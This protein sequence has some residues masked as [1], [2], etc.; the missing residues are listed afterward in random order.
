MSAPQPLSFSHPGRRPVWYSPRHGSHTLTAYIAC[1][2]RLCAALLVCA[3]V[4]ARFLDWSARRGAPDHAGALR[5]MRHGALPDG[6]T[7]RWLCPPAS[8]PRGCWIPDAGYLIFTE[9]TAW[10]RPRGDRPME[11]LCG[12]P[13]HVRQ[14]VGRAATACCSSTAESSRRPERAQVDSTS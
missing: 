2:R 10:V 7:M 6:R 8:S 13:A 14:A 1:A 12:G 4:Q 11:Q 5:L 3:G 9:T